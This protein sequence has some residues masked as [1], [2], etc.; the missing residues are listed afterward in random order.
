MARLEHVHQY[1]NLTEQHVMDHQTFRLQAEL[2]WLD[3]V[4]ADLPAIVG[5]RDDQ[6]ERLTCPRPRPP[7]APSRSRPAA[8]WIAFAVV[9]VG[10]AMSLIDTTI[11]NVALPYDQVALN[12][13]EATLSWI[14]SGYALAFGLALIPA[15]R[16]GDRIGHKWV[17]FTGIALFTAASFACGIVE[18]DTQLIV[19]RVVQGLA[20]GIFVPAVTAFIQLLFPAQV[21]GR[22][23]AI[24]G[25][26]IG[27]SRLSA[28]SSAAC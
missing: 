23:F 12:A 10:A 2:D 25:T 21:R 24:M 22:A 14:I 17:Y 18:S 15:G 3:S 9:L 27:V 19:F 6:R 8:A 11:V 13:S 4:L 28:R 16:I 1:L 20:G 26:V 7:W 5:R